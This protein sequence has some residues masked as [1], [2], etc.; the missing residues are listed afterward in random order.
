M[1]GLLVAIIGLLVVVVL[2]GGGAAFFYARSKGE[3]DGTGFTKTSGSA[4]AVGATAAPATASGAASTT[5]PG[6]TTTVAAATAPKAGVGG[7]TPAGAVKPAGATPSA[8]P[9]AAPSASAAPAATQ[10]QM[11]GTRWQIRGGTFNAYDIEQSRASVMKMSGAIQT[12]YN[13]TEF[14]PPNHEFTNFQFSVAPTGAVTSVVMISSPPHPKFG[15]CMIA[16]LRQVRF[17]ALPGGGTLSITFG[18]RT[19]ENE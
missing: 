13:T 1:V 5:G 16:S 3:N 12:C 14:D 6:A 17:Q 9:S 10:K 15:P 18:A 11:A 7:T 8:I 2:V 4:P 19:K